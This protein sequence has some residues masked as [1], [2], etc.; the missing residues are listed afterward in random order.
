LRTRRFAKKRRE[1]KKESN[2]ATGTDKRVPQDEAIRGRAIYI[3][4]AAS[5]ISESLARL[6]QELIPGRLFVA[7][8]SYL[9]LAAADGKV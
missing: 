6:Q 4:L 3:D 7:V 5:G 2:N 1:E 9:G 8:C